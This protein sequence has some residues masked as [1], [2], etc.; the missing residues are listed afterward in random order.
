M[1][2]MELVVE[3]VLPEFRDRGEAHAKWRDEQTADLPVPVSS[4]V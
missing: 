3:Q 2:S 4:T 1:E